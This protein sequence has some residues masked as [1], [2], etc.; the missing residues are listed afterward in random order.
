MKTYNGID[1]ELQKNVQ[2]LILNNQLHFLEELEML[3]IY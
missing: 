3:I 1:L 2:K